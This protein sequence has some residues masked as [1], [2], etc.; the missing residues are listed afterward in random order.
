MPEPAQSRIL[1]FTDH[2]WTGVRPI[3]YKEPGEDWNSVTRHPLVGADEGTPFHVRYFEI[4]PGGHSSFERHEHQHA[5]IVIRGRGAV[6]FGEGWE[7][8]GF[9]DVV[10]VTGDAPHQFRA[11]GDEPFGFIC[12]V[13]AERDRPIPLED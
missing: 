11:V 3:A 9:G 7:D 6:R 2:T 13:A 8:V 4:E 5:V 12:V 10:Y 1:R